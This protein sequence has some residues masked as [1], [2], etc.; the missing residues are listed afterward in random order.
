M[1]RGGAIIYEDNRD[2]NTR[3]EQMKELEDEYLSNYLCVHL[4]YERRRGEALA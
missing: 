1:I 2:T 4:R 3:S